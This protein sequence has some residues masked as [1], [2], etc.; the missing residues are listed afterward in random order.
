MRRPLAAAMVT[1]VTTTRVIVTGF[2]GLGF[3][4]FTADGPRG[5][6][7]VPG[8]PLEPIAAAFFGGMLVLALG[9]L[10]SASKVARMRQKEQRRQRVGACHGRCVS[11]G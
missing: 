3:V 4:V 6:D 1:S 2:G 11:H 10:M 8:V 5:R 7:L 9:G